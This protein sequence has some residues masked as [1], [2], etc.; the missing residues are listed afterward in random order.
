MYV[1][2]RGDLRACANNL[3]MQVRNYIY[4]THAIHL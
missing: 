3:S 1:E 4:N 2:F